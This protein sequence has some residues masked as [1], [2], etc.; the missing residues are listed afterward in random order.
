MPAKPSIL[1]QSTSFLMLSLCLNIPT[2]CFKTANACPFCPA[3]SLTY[4]EQIA[5]ADFAVIAIWTDGTPP[6]TNL[7]SSGTTLLRFQTSVKET[8]SALTSKPDISL[9]QYRPAKTGQRFLVFGKQSEGEIEWT[10]CQELSSECEKYLS[11]APSPSES[12]SVRLTYYMQYLE[13]SQQSIAID[14]YSEFANA[15]YEEVAALSELMPR[16]Q[17][18]I[19]LETADENPD[20]EIRIGLYGLMLGLCGNQSDADFLKA[21]IFNS[22]DSRLGFNG[23]VA[24]YLVLAGRPG[25][26]FI[27]NQ[28]L[29][30]PQADL[31]QRF[32]VMEAL[33]FLWT[34]EQNPAPKSE[35]IKTMRTML[36]DSRLTA[37]AIIDL[38]RWQ[39]WDSVERIASLYNRAGYDDPN[40][41]KTIIRYLYLASLAKSD[42]DDSSPS[43]QKAADALTA[44]GQQDPEIVDQAK[45]YLFLE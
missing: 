10:S 3:A 17:I 31:N 29:T 5:G 11:Q 26:E 33:R 43:A 19:W 32:A 34:Y 13:H 35:L 39:D 30:S 18:R 7:E 38:A 45:K 42:G 36:T 1:V 20:R 12:S 23:L 14:A 41:K 37:L 16:E 2:A 27:R 15:S 28:I 6:D 21:E 4:S 44:I 25:M 40:T 8:N 9:S 24:G 22:K